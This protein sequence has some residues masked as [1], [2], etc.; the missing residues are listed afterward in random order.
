MDRR[1][2]GARDAAPIDPDPAEKGEP[3]EP[4]A[5]QPAAVA[6][7]PEPQRPTASLDALPIAGLSRRR[8]A[9]ALGAIV[10]L[11]IVW[12]FARQV[13]DASAA[14]AR[15]DEIRAENQAIATEVDALTAE[16]ELIQKQAYIEQQARGYG[17]GTP[18]E[19]PFSLPADAPTPG[20]DAPGSA[21]VRLG[22]Q[23][24]QRSPLDAWMSVLFGPDGGS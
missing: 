11:W 17:L 7:A 10:A 23:V 21:A 15:A 8:A 3:A 12:V 13:G 22:A 18:R 20:P 14:S 16:R 6:A 1:R 4:F 24:V 5:D 2:L 19:R 9:F